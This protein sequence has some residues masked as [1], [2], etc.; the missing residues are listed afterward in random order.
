MI[1]VKWSQLKHRKRQAATLSWESEEAK[2]SG[3]I[4]RRQ[5]HGAGLGT[6]QAWKR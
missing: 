5:A 6:H 1:A 2:L 4:G 3:F